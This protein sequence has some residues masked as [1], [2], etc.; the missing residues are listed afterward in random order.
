MAATTEDQLA[1]FTS[2]E[3]C[4]GDGSSQEEQTDHPPDKSS[5]VFLSR[6]GEY[7][8]ELLSPED[9]ETVRKI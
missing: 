5:Q 6:L 9:T 2:N 7:Q 3:C 4:D 1:V 8:V